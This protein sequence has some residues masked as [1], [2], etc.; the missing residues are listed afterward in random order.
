M[1]EA[2]ESTFQ[3]SDLNDRNWLLG[4]RSEAVVDAPRFAP[5]SGRR[6]FHSE[7]VVLNSAKSK[8]AD[9]WWVDS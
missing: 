3:R 4:G 2:H 8:T 9:V 1:T 6:T 5:V 7:S